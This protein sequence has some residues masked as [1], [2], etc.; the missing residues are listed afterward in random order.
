VLVDDLRGEALHLPDPVLDHVLATIVEPRRALD[1]LGWKV[2]LRVTEVT[3]EKAHRVVDL[4]VSPRSVMRDAYLGLLPKASGAVHPLREAR[5]LLL[6]EV[7]E[8]D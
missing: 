7:T 4:C 1:R 2:D 8:G 6:V 5:V 3:R